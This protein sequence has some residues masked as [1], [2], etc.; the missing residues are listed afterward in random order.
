MRPTCPD[1]PSPLNGT[2]VPFFVELTSLEHSSNS[3]SLFNTTLSDS[4]KAERG[5]CSECMSFYAVSCC[6]VSLDCSA[7]RRIR[8][9][10]PAAVVATRKHAIACIPANST[11]TPAYALSCRSAVL[12]AVGYHHP[13][14]RDRG[15]TKCDCFRWSL[16]RCYFDQC[17][18]R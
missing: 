11:S 17:S 14:A 3:C 2:N 8:D 6:S 5:V 18:F 12:F 7:A 1:R 15:R 16:Q 4:A 13:F 10:S 9:R